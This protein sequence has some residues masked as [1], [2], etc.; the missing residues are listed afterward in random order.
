MASFLKCIYCGR[1]DFASQK[2]LKQ[3]QS[4]N[5]K[6][7]SKL[8]G[9]LNLDQKLPPL[10][11]KALQ[12]TQLSHVHFSGS[13][14]K[15]TQT[16]TNVATNLVG[17]PENNTLTNTRKRSIDDSSHYER[18]EEADITTN[19]DMVETEMDPNEPPIM[20]NGPPLV[21]TPVNVEQVSNELRSSFQKHVASYLRKREFTAKEKN[22]INLIHT[23][24]QSSAS[25]GMYDSIMHWHLV[26]NGDIR[27]HQKVKE[28][29]N[30]LNQKK[31]FKLLRN[32]YNFENGYHN[33]SEMI[34]PNSRARPKLFGMM[35]KHA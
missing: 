16:C 29:F 13:L 20:L 32:R 10:P 34:L 26:A 8:K 12:F 30:Y 27:S 31:I 1:A 17:P 6:C 22:A 18:E 9:S 21:A 3:H 11:A 24:R 28:S 35:L 33:Q 2:G 25:L 23:L 14:I 5:K 4:S 19:F 15:F 7:L